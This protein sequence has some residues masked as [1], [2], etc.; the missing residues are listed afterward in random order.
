MAMTNKLLAGQVK[1]F[2]FASFAIW[3][4]ISFVNSHSRV[5]S[6]RYFEDIALKIVLESRLQRDPPIS[7]RSLLK[8]KNEHKIHF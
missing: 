1:E 6:G 7:S 2:L 8:Y 3:F 5:Q 4:L